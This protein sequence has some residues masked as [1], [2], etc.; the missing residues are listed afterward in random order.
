MRALAQVP[1]EVHY[2][3]RCV[4]QY[5]VDIIV[6]GKVILEL[7]AAS[8]LNDIHRAQ[9]L[10]YLKASQIRL[11]LLLNFGKTRLQNERFAL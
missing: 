6:E 7:K 4:G 10:N 3:G 2:L 11:G 5:E 1:I 8:A 9:L